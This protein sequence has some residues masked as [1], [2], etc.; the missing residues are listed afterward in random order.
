MAYFNRD[1][2]NSLFTSFIR[3][4]FWIFLMRFFFV[5]RPSTYSQFQLRKVKCT[6][7]FGPALFRSLSK[8][9]FILPLV[10]VCNRFFEQHQCQ[11]HRTKLEFNIPNVQTGPF[12]HSFIHYFSQKMKQTHQ[13]PY[14]LGVRASDRNEWFPGLHLRFQPLKLG[15]DNQMELHDLH[16]LERLYHSFGKMKFWTRWLSPSINWNSSVLEYG[17]SV[18][19]ICFNWII[20][21]SCEHVQRFCQMIR[22]NLNTN[23]LPLFNSFAV[24][25]NSI[26]CINLW[27]KW[28]WPI[29]FNKMP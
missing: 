3:G 19:S 18:R 16:G 11:W 14:L 17:I 15:C 27:N 24:F 10:K 5:F 2:H 26:S 13:F 9:K 25:G 12:M 29:W 8:I 7:Y 1:A 4:I 6:L 21:L 20:G 23:E 22:I 28:K